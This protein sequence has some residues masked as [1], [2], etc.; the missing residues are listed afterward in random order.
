MPGIKTYIPRAEPFKAVKW[1]GDNLDEVRKVMGWDIHP[2]EWEMNCYFLVDPNAR[3]WPGGQM[4]ILTA[5]VFEKQYTQQ[6]EKQT[7]CQ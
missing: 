7:P 2:A 3:D 5:D 4:R 1:T 6:E